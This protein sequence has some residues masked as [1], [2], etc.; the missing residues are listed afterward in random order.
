MKRLT[1][2]GIELATVDRGAGLPLLLVHG[3]PLDH[4]MWEAQI[5]ALGQRHRVIAPDLRGFG[6]SGLPDGKVTM[7]QF[8]DDLAG[9]L[10]GLGAAEPVVFCGLSMGG[11]IA[12]RFWRRHR[13]RL[14]GLILCDTRA[15]ADSP[16]TAANRLALAERVLREGPLPVADAMVPNLT[17]EITAK[18]RPEVAEALRRMILANR[19]HGIAAA[20]RGMAER[21]DM[22]SM[23]HQIDC[24]TLVLVG[25][26]DAISTPAEMRSIAEAIPD[27]RLVEIS[28]AGHM[29]PM[30]NPAEVNAAI[31]A[32]LADLE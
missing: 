15:S 4:T 12:W 25:R 22:T 17:A 18:T 5:E 23:L 9:L 6:A 2:Q 24:P 27:A 3:F 7:D 29:S 10:D 16:E 8:A 28:A 30:E 26:N 14:R 1:V 31:G 21:M 20:S 11:Y 13:D 32:F 19:P